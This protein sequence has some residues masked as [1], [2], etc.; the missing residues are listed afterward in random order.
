MASITTDEVYSRF[1]T[2]AEAF[3]LA[4]F[5]DDHKN[6]VDDMLDEWFRSAMFYPHIQK[7]FSEFNYDSEEKL[8]MFEMQYPINDQYDRE[9]ILDVL[10]YGMVYGWVEPKI[11]SIT[12]I[13]QF[14]GE[15][16]SKYFSQAMHLSELRALRDDIELKI[17]RLI[18]ERGFFRNQYLDGNSA[19]ASLR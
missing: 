15:T 3:D 11:N 14:F 8:I 13:I 19:S 1:F 16:D 7:L 5:D 10:S 2:K 4:R 6:V 12:N 18:R 9:F 17:R